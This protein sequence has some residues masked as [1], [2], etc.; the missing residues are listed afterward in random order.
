MKIHSESMPKFEQRQIAH[1]DLSIYS[2]KEAI[3]KSK[4]HWWVLWP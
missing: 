3:S 4:N 2:I 1:F